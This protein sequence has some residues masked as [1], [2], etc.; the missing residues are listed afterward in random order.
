[1]VVA[2]TIL[3]GLFIA[4]KSCGP[5]NALTSSLQESVIAK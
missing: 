1:M 2:D 5:P 3:G 4:G